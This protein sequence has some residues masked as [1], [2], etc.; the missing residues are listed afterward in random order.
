MDSKNAD[1]DSLTI[2]CF[3]KLNSAAIFPHPCHDLRRIF[4]AIQSCYMHQESRSALVMFN[5]QSV[6]LNMIHL[7][8]NILTKGKCFFHF[9]RQMMNHKNAINIFKAKAA[10]SKIPAGGKQFYFLHPH[11]LHTPQCSSNINFTDLGEEGRGILIITKQIGVH[12]IQKLREREILQSTCL[13]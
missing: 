10:Q 5:I 2:L 9:A 8:I 7:Y 1:S 6:I 12:S 11:N 3:G 4:Q 13:F